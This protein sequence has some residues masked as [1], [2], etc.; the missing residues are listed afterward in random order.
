MRNVYIL[1]NKINGKMYVG[2]TKNIKTRFQNH[3]KP[4]NNR[5]ALNLAIKKYGWNNFDK[6]IFK[7]IPYNLTDCFEIELIKRLNT[8]APNGYNIE[9]GGCSKKILSEEHKNKIKKTKLERSKQGLYANSYNA[10]KSN[11]HKNN[12]SI[13]NKGKH[14]HVGELNPKFGKFNSVNTRNKIKISLAKK[15][16]VREKWYAI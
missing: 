1:K 15:Y 11:S 16:R 7:D 8:L 13:S 10:P 5:M 9:A 2:Q 14:P 4:S 3:R 12:L 6:Y